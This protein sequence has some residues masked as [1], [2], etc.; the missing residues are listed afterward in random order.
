MVNYYTLDEAAR[1]LQ[2][3]PDKLREM[4]NRKEVRAFQDR[5][6]LR[7]RAQEIDE[8]ARSR[9][10]GSDPEVQL[11]ESG[12]KSLGPKSSG[13][14]SPSPK[15]PGTR[16]RDSGARLVD[17]SDLDFAVDEGAHPSPK[18]AKP[19]SK[20]G[21]PKSSGVGRKSKLVDS[22]VRLSGDKDPNDSDVKIP[23]ED[24]QLA[25]PRKKRPSDSDI[26]LED[27]PSL[28]RGNAGSDPALITE[29][30]DLDAEARKRP[31]PPR[32]RTRPKSSLKPNAPGLPTS[33]PFE[34]SE[35]D[36]TLDEPGKP[37]LG[38]GGAARKKPKE[39]DSSSEFELIPFDHTKSPNDLGSG[40]IPLL[41]GDEEV[42]LG[43]EPRVGPGNSGL[44]LQDPRD[45]GL[46]LEQGGSDELE[47]ELTVD[48]TASPNPGSRSSK[49]S[50]NLT[51]DSSS[52]FELSLD[53]APSDPSESEFELSLDE[54][55]SNIGL[56]Q[57]DD[58]SDSELELTLDEEGGLSAADSNVLDSDEKDIFEETNFDVPALDND[59][60]SEAV[61]LEDGDTDLEASDFE[62]SLDDDSD[63]GDRSDSQVVAVE[64]ED[65][66]AGAATVARAR[67]TKPKS[68]VARTAVEDDAGDLDLDL[69]S[70][71][72]KKK[73][74]KRRDVEEEDDQ[75]EDVEAGP[76]VEAAPAEWGPVPAILLFPTVIVLF[77]VGLMAFEL[78]QGMWGYHRSTKVGTPVIK[79][80]AGM[81]EDLPKDN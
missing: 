47:F 58:N 52:E 29:E 17:D 49:S 72:A 7:F 56:K 68:K 15:S 40:E 43:A 22:G 20:L 67:K 16:K 1:I 64:G 39:D 79:A 46:S 61:A 34:L 9:G 36:L 63:S 23:D 54:G 77:V 11:G 65:A 80:I 6:T 35:H 44:N 71:G 33:S 42:S 69:D 13:P 19:T 5:G 48:G 53:E 73:P 51:E 26:R 37:R 32:T 75:E 28:N 30:I 41:S 38:A 12:L 24:V 66:D 14:R 21:G 57:L 76:V 25:P 3:T 18:P 8:L 4:A 27:L 62:I 10:L 2:T 55:G 45:S 81:F 78:V 74:K 70:S 59:S 31:D 50:K 60:G